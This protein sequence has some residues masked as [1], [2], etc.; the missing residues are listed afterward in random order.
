MADI[1]GE[2]DA[3]EVSWTNTDAGPV[4]V[5][6]VT[7]ALGASGDVHFDFAEAETAGPSGLPATSLLGGVLQCA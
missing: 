3:L 1:N 7:V 6:F 5:W 2:W 4:E